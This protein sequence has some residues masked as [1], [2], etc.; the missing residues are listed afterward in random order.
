MYRVRKCYVRSQLFDI[1]Y[2]S[3][4]IG[5]GMHVKR[6]SF[7]FRFSLLV[8]FHA[9]KHDIQVKNGKP[10]M[11]ITDCGQV[12][13]HNHGLIASDVDRSRVQHEL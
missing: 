5:W 12:L 9:V 2:I 7:L 10:A 1:I 3:R 8:P 6:N 11:V 4:V 13:W